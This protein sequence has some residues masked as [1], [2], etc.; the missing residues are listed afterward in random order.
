M[1]AERLVTGLE[2]DDGARGCEGL[3]LRQDINPPVRALGDVPH[4]LTDL[5]QHPF[6]GDDLAVASQRQADQVS[7]ESGRGHG[8][9]E[10]IALPGREFVAAVDDQVAGVAA[11][12]PP[13]D[14]KSTRLN[15]SH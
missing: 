8:G 9:D 6:L 7:P 3:G 15:S 12:R 11:P 5:A 13:L 4:P 10:D 14:R 2:H 1:G